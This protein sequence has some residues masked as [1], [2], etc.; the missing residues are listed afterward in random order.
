MRI[1]ALT[2]AVV[3][4]LAA[5]PAHADDDRFTLRL[6]G[7]WA[8]GENE[9]RGRTVFD[10]EDVFFRENIDFGSREFSP[11][12]DGNFKIS[13]RNRLVFN[14]FN[15]GKDRNTT[16]DEAI[17][18]DDVTIPAGSFARLDTDFETA[19]LVYDFAVIE[20]E[21]LSWGLQIGAQYASLEGRLVAEAGTDRYSDRAREDGY[22]PVV[23]SRLTLTPNEHWRFELQGQ[24]LDA[25]WG[26]FGDYDGSLGRASAIVEYRFSP[27]F[28]IYG[29]YDWFRLDV[30]RDGGDGVFGFDQRFQGPTAGVSVSF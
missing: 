29:G 19:N 6:G 23:G 25:N 13:D 7:T 3:V 14:Y 27:T 5:M 28:G 1:T 10:G 20:N 21:E 2:L 18:F 8:E 12:L 17:S 30:E 16:L 15:Y 11:H 9:L 26:D 4:G 22:A 24:Y